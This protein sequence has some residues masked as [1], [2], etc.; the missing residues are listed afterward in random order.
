MQVFSSVVGLCLI[1]TQL[2][3]QANFTFDANRYNNN[4]QRVAIVDASSNSAGPSI[5]LHFRDFQLNSQDDIEV[6]RRP[7]DG[8]AGDW[9]LKANLTAGTEYYTDQDVILGQSYE[10]QVKKVIPNSEESATTYLLAG[11]EHN[12]YDY[13]GRMILLID[14]TI[15][16]PLEA[17][18]NQLR[19]DLTGAGYFVELLTAPRIEGWHGGIEVVNV[20]QSIVDVYNAAPIEDKPTHLFILGHVPVP[21]SGGGLQAPDGHVESLGA[22]GADTYYADIDGVFTD[23]MSFNPGNL[24]HPEAVNLPNDY[25]WD[26]D[27][28]PSELELAFGRVDFADVY[29]QSLSEVELLKSYLDRLHAYKHVIGDTDMGDKTAFYYGYDNSNDGSFRSLPPISGV[30]NVYEIANNTNMP[31]TI[32]ETGPY[33]IFMQNQFVPNSNEWNAS[34]MDATIFS[35]DQSYWGFWCSEENESYIGHIRGLLSKPTKCLSILW[36]TTAVNIFHQLGLGETIGYA[37]RRIMNHNSTNNLYEKPE[38]DW[39]TN[40]WWNR[41]HMQVLG[42]PTLRIN[43]VR[44]I[45]NLTTTELS[46]SAVLLNWTASTEPSLVGYHIYRAD[47]E[48]GPYD[49]IS[50]DIVT[51]TEFLHESPKSNGS[52]YMVRAIKLETT[53]SGSYLNPSQGT[54]I[55]SGFFLNNELTELESNLIILY[56]CPADD[57]VTLEGPL[58]NYTFELIDSRGKMIQPILSSEEKHVIDIG[59]L[60][61]GC[62]FIKTTSKKTGNT[63]ILTVVKQ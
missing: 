44:P 46:S 38:S 25:K 63:G 55:Q 9:L 14:E 33:Q 30:D 16:E 4:G 47:T 45:A 50:T 34:G 49:R 56:P 42:D 6:Y 53:G 3:G 41:N 52:W 40:D 31:K 59:H 61:S 18:I 48:S 24:N 54:M 7:I 8:N 1:C 12:Q 15:V 26:Q 20:K 17:E 13:N 10:Y 11:V 39:D 57:F 43:Q 5:T 22:R 58:D 62:F 19:Q 28:I 21:R 60:E 32:S 36:T 37:T 2:Y 23:D 27:H 51:S 29:S 35:S